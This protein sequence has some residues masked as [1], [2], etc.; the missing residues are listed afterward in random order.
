MRIYISQVAE[1]RRYWYNIRFWCI[2]RQKSP[3]LARN[4]PNKFQYNANEIQRRIVSARQTSALTNKSYSL[5]SGAARWINQ[6]YNY[7]YVQ[8]KV[9]DF[10]NYTTKTIFVLIKLRPLY[11]RGNNNLSEIF[12]RLEIFMFA[13]NEIG[14]D[15]RAYIYIYI[16][17]S[18]C[19]P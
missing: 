2:F 5:L 18:I 6:L 10:T 13:K 8:I 16:N 3:L 1:I 14:L 19:C 9:L 11:A 4:F 17:I 7:T 15:K 12:I